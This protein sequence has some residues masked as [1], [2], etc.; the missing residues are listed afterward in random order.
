MML[1]TAIGGALIGAL[2]RA[3]TDLNIP[4]LMP[5]SIA[6]SFPLQSGD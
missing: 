6:P 4:T 3:M 2:G 1:N 5:I